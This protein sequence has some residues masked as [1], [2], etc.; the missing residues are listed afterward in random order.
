MARHRHAVTVRADGLDAVLASVV[1]DARVVAAALV[2]VDSGMVLDACGPDA[3]AEATMEVCAAGHAELVRVARGLPGLADSDP[4]THAMTVSAGPSTHHLLRTIPDPHGDL[5]VLSVQVR[6]SKRFAERVRKRLNGV[7]ADALTAGPTAVRRPGVGGW[8]LGRPPAPGPAHPR[9]PFPVDDRLDPRQAHPRAGGLFEP[10]PPRGLPAQPVPAQPAPAQPAPTE[11]GRYGWPSFGVD[12]PEIRPGGPVLLGVDLSGGSA[13]RPAPA[14]PPVGG[15]GGPGSVHGP[16][17]AGAPVGG[18]GPGGS[19]PVFAGGSG[20]PGSGFPG[21][22]GHPG[23][24]GGAHEAGPW[25]RS[26]DEAADRRGPGSPERPA[27]VTGGRPAVGSALPTRSPAPYPAPPP[28]AAQWPV[29]ARP[30]GPDVPPD[31]RVAPP[32]RPVAP[33][34]RL[35]APRPVPRPVPSSGSAGWPV[36]VDP[37]PAGPVLMGPA[38]VD[39]AAVPGAQPD[40]SPQ[41]PVPVGGP[42][43]DVPAGWPAPAR[44]MP[45]DGWVADR[46]GLDDREPAPLFDSR[47][48]PVLLGRPDPADDWPADAGGAVEAR[49]TPHSRESRDEGPRNPAPP[50]ALP[51]GRQG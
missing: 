11:A 7:G 39:S 24:A 8:S 20:F 31:R 51:P 6:G 33:P 45:H 19:G 46:A 2:D 25:S 38:P 9:P 49:P 40:G 37:V 50:S 17:G 27:E 12:A 48:G 29:P 14:G 13:G 15:P 22:G 36:P 10:S 18:S 23:P 4:A 34:D 32:D 5:L 44:S 43:Q 47:P 26:P 28:G 16:D 42:P 21:S 35:V 3:A 1:N 30:N 41:W